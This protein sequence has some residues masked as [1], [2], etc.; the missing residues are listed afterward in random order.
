M[1]NARDKQHS[2]Q[3]SDVHP[4]APAF[5]AGVGGFRPAGVAGVDVGHDHIPVGSPAARHV[6][7]GRRSGG[8]RRGAHES[9][10]SRLALLEEGAKRLSRARFGHAL[11]EF[12]KALW[13]KRPFTPP[14]ETKEELVLVQ[15]DGG[16]PADAVLGIFDTL[17]KW[18]FD[19]AEFVQLVL[20]YAVV[21]KLGKEAFDARVASHIPTGGRFLLRVHNSTGLKPV[22]GSQFEKED[23]LLMTVERR[24]AVMKEQEQKFGGTANGS[25]IVFTNLDSRSNDKVY[26]HENTIKM[27]QDRFIAHGIA[28]GNPFVTREQIF[29]VLAKDAVGHAADE[30]YK[31]TNLYISSIV[32]YGDG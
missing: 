13:E 7:W 19:C 25:Q 10:K 32:I 29:K 24:K 30:Q 14:G 31:K 26:E 4:D 16:S 22:G 5:H 20:L 15:K 17:D 3:H 27:G 11:G 6:V 12:D 18:S 1:T 9:Q 23:V 21:K 28:R 8:L 2:H